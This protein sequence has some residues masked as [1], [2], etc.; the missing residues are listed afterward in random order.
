MKDVSRGTPRAAGSNPKSVKIKEKQHLD[1]LE[2]KSS[3]K[4]TGEC[5]KEDSYDMNLLTRDVDIDKIIT[6]TAIQEI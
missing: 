4:L 6:V 2:Q 5:R 3:K 1:N